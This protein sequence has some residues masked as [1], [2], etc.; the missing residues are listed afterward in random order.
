MDA[1]IVPS[2]KLPRGEI[3]V[4]LLGRLAVDQAAQGQGLGRLCLLRAM[5]Q[6]ERAAQ[7]IGIYA[8]VLDAVD[9]KARAWYLNLPFGFEILHDDP[10]HLYLPVETIRQIGLGE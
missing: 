4:V 7:E 5:T 6:V 8:L 10:N 3:G 2:K 1:E 9:E